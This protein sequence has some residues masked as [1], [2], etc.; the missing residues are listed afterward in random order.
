LAAGEG[1]ELRFCHLPGLTGEEWS[2]E[3]ACKIS[4]IRF[5]M[6]PGVPA[7]KSNCGD[8]CGNCGD[9]AVEY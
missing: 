8:N 2:A 6:E 7:Q 1:F 5:F 3:K 9:E 4:A